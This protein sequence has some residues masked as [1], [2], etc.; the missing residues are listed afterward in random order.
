MA[1]WQRLYDPSA[2]GRQ[3]PGA[4]Q[5]DRQANRRP[6]KIQ[7]VFQPESG[8]AWNCLDLKTFKNPKNQKAA[9]SHE[10]HESHGLTASHRKEGM[11]GVRGV[12]VRQSERPHW[13][14]L[15]ITSHGWPHHTTHRRV[16]GSV[17]KLEWIWKKN[18]NYWPIDLWP[19]HP[20]SSIFIHIHPILCSLCFFVVQVQ[21]PF[22]GQVVQV[23]RSCLHVVPEVDQCSHGGGLLQTSESPEKRPCSCSIHWLPCRC[24]N[25]LHSKANINR[26]NGLV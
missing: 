17:R 5:L 24:S 26:I 19:I 13:S 9:Q 15:C 25:G 12:H 3:R 16:V 2:G 11:P 4:G 21:V 8:T 1:S 22:H 18:E 14:A 10:S 6:E 23:L 20:Y 7:S